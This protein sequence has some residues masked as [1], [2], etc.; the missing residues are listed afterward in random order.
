[1]THAA[2]MD[3]HKYAKVHPSDPEIPINSPEVMKIPTPMVPLIPIAIVEAV[4]NIHVSRN[5]GEITGKLRS[6]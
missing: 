5:L 3:A 2:V 6:S 4:R 1:M